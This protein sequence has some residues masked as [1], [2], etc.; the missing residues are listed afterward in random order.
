MRFLA[1]DLGYSNVKLVYG[2]SL[3]D[4]A[5][6]LYPAAAGPL[7]LR[8][9]NVNGGGVQGGITVLVDGEPYSAFVPASSFQNFSRPVHE[10]YIR[11]RSY[12]ALYYAALH[13]LNVPEVEE[14]VT[15]L[16]T[17]HYLDAR[18]RDELIRL[19]SGA[20]QITPHMRVHVRRVKVTA[21]PVGAFVDF[22]ASANMPGLAQ[23]NVLV[24]DPG[25]G[26]TDW[27]LIHSGN[28][29]D[30]GSGSSFQA[31]SVVLEGAAKLINADLGS[32][33]TLDPLEIALRNG[34]DVIYVYGE[35]VTITPYLERAAEPVVGRVIDDILRQ[36]RTEAG[37]IDVILLTGGGA[38]FFQKALKGAINGP[39]IHHMPDPVFANARG[40]YVASLG[41]ASKRQAAA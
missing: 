11:S 22:M 33:I 23:S 14:V 9:K 31:M 13:H 32:R 24:V 39:K 34:E 4:M 1:V 35:P 40:Y 38:R 12:R 26:S 10:D 3:K 27:A 20:H 6:I 16:P 21:Q 5:K 15:G 7:S 28:L 37:H 29:R 8:D 17:K 2:S 25:F 30:S 41:A 18:F 36:S 19:M